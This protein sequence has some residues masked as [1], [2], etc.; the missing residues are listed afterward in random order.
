MRDPF[1]DRVRASVEAAL[2]RLGDKAHVVAHER[3]GGGCIHNGTRV[4][5]DTGATYFLKWN[6]SPTPGMFAAEAEGLQALRDGS[7]LRIPEP[8]VWSD[9]DDGPFAWLLMEY[10][11]PGPGSP[12]SNRALGERLAGMHDG[13]DG[14]ASF[15]WPSD[16]WIGSLAQANRETGSWAAFWRDTRLRPQLELARRHGRLPDERFDRVLDLAPSGLAGVVRPGLV[17]GDLWSGNTF[18]CRS[19]E[20]VLVDPAVYRGEGEVDLAMSELFGGFGA[21]FYSAYDG[22]RPIS[23]EYRSFRRELYQL[24]YLLVHVNLFGA[25]YE[26]GA[27]RAATRVLHALR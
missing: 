5:M 26:A 3:V 27:L 23:P 22:V 9:G 10:V 14:G 7:E 13:G 17:H 25:T 8:R 12:A 16:N 21:D 4:V 6:D 18:T 20:P 15:G 1:P 19:G 2:A 24:Y 11:E